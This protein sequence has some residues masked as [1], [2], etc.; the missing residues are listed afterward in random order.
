MPRKFTKKKFTRKS[1]T[2]KKWRQQKLSVGTVAKIAKKIANFQIQKKAE[3]KYSLVQIGDAAPNF[4]SNPNPYLLMKSGAYKLNP[5][6]VNLNS[7]NLNLVGFHPQTIQ[8]QAGGGVIDTSH[9]TRN[10]DT[11]QLKR[12][13][14]S[15]TLVLPSGC[16]NAR[17]HIGI[18]SAKS[19][20][21]NPR[22]KLPDADFMTMRRS[23]DDFQELNHVVSKTWVVNKTAGSSIE[24]PGAVQNPFFEGQ[25]RKINF[26]LTKYFKN[27]R[28]RY[29]EDA[30]NTI[31]IQNFSD[32]RYYLV[33][34]SDVPDPS[35]N[36]GIGQQ[37][38]ANITRLQN[39][40]PLVYG[41]W[42]SYYRDM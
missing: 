28:I 23:I 1:R 14:F 18:Y 17:V 8:P 3:P 26:N 24:N 41:K 35:T 36:G 16:P 7:A 30:N 12:V 34:Y 42:L 6:P 33:M 21:N 20:Q 4:G 31:P 9:G 29:D 5:G 40:Y 37:P 11:I 13:A 38:N 10:G 19:T 27:R 32:L 25:I 39:N 2:R 15:G 22:A